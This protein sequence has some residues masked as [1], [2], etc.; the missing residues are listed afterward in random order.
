MVNSYIESAENIC[1]LQRCTWGKVDV[2]EINYRYY[3]SQKP[4]VKEHKA[5]FGR[6]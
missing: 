4:I 3:K 6:T 5:R 1:D 2:Y